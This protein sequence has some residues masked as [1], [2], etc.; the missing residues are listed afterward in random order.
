MADKPQ[1]DWRALAQLAADEQDPE[2]LF[3]I[4]NELNAALLEREQQRLGRA[5]SKRLLLVDDDQNVRLTLLPVLQQGGFEVQLAATV[6]EALE[7]IAKRKFELLVSDL[8]VSERNDGFKVVAAMRQSRPRSVIVLLTGYP[9]FESAVE[10]IH[11]EVD[12]YL[13]KPADYD[14]LIETLEK[15]LAAKRG[16]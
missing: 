5:L 2:K 7:Q 6:D 9:A 11:H 10:G 1:K 4:I 15:K 8:N 14:A 16:F 12:D 13:V 3:E